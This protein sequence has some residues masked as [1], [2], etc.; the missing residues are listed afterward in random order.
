V[1]SKYYV[2]NPIVPLAQTKFVLNLD[3]VGTGH[4]G[5][6]V[7]NATVFPEYFK[8]L[9]DINDTYNYL[10][11]ITRRG[12]AA[13]SDHYFFTEAG[14][15]AFFGYFQGERSSYHDVFDV[16]ETLPLT[17]YID[18]RELFIKFLEVI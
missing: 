13:N 9:T 12:K 4:K 17:K 14:V 18:G 3:L 1:G 6:T 16:P 8:K 15:P 10:P 7:V 11:Q 2:E 5:M